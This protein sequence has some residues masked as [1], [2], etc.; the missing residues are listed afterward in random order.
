MS[1]GIVAASR[2]PSLDFGEVSLY[3]LYRHVFRPAFSCTPQETRAPGSHP[4]FVFG[5]SYRLANAR[6][7]GL[8]PA[9]A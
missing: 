5:L 6:A 9:E 4:K 8:N 1:S 7:G 3:A 2:C